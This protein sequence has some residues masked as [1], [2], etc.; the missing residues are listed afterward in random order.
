MIIWRGW[1]ILVVALAAGPLLVTPWLADAVLGDGYYASHGWPKFVALASAAVIVWLFSKMLDTRP[2]RVV[3][4]P[5]T[6]ERVTIGG[7]DHLFFVP[8]RIWPAL[9]LAAGIGFAMFGPVP[10]AAPEASRAAAG[11]ADASLTPALDTTLPQQVRASL[12]AA[13]GELAGRWTG[14]V[15]RDGIREVVVIEAH[16]A[17]GFRGRSFFEDGA[18]VAVGGRGSVSG[19][20]SDGEMTFTIS[21]DGSDLVW[22]GSKTVDG[23]ALVGRFDGNSTDAIYRRP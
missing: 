10:P 16:N 14:T 11:Q 18:G 6:G 9:L 7:G 5:H 17:D 1:G 8:V 20:S 4:D 15:G 13:T 2:G 3:V 22:S 21:R 19:T 23:R 12:A